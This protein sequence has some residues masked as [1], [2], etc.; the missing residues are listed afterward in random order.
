MKEYSLRISSII[1]RQG[2]NLTFE[3]E[4]VGDE[5]PAY[6]AGQFLILSFQ[7][8]NREVRRSYSLSSS[9]YTGEPLSITVKRIDNGEISRLLHHKTQVGDILTA[10]EPQGV[11]TY[12]PEPER[13]RIVFLF[14]AGIGIT[15]LYSI[16]KTALVA[17][18]QS[19]IVLVYSNSSPEKAPFLEE[20]REWEARY[21]DRLKVIWLFSNN[22]NLMQARLNRFILEDFVKQH[23]PYAPDDALFYTCGPVIYMDLC[24]ITLLGM[25]FQP[26]QIKRETF[27]PPENEEDD[28]DET[29]KV[30]DTHTY[31]VEL[32]FNGLTHHLLVP[33]TNSILDEAL[34]K[35]IRLPYSCRSGMCSTCAAWCRNGSVK[36][37]YNEVLTEDEMA[38]GRVL[39]CTAH[40]TQNG[41][42]IEYD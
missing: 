1:P 13:K 22:K 42:V 16:L 7:F 38:R 8:G 25:G 19:R 29:I 30:V 12:E 15:P 32:R 21:S 28:D 17:E 23:L 41:T 27:L 10:L 4:P 6:K 14:A 35:G 24:R 11:F 33:Y 26:E 5:I 18:N 31:S 20:I 36:M 2:D 40:P 3:L 37:D 34:D 39:V 9:P